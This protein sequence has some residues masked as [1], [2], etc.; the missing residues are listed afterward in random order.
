MI[1]D[2]LALL[3]DTDVR[4][5]LPVFPVGDVRVVGPLGLLNESFGS[6]ERFSS[7]SEVFLRRSLRLAMKFFVSGTT[8]S[9]GVRR[10]ER[11]TKARPFQRRFDLPDQY[12]TALG[13]RFGFKQVTFGQSEKVVRLSFFTPVTYFQSLTY[14]SPQCRAVEKATYEF[15]LLAGLA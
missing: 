10:G 1:T 11:K 7:Q 9:R 8:Q 4:R 13:D 2:D 12:C 3:E 6:G 14:H 5:P 15:L